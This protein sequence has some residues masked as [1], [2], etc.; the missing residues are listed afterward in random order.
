[1]LRKRRVRRPSVDQEGA[2]EMIGLIANVRNGFRYC[3]PGLLAAMPAPGG[4]AAT[5]AGKRTYAALTA[6]LHPTAA[7]LGAGADGGS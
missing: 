4:E 1:M 5:T 7:V 2:E 3:L 6:A